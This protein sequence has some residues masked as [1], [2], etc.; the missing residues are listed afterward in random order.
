MRRKDVLVKLSEDY[1]CKLNRIH[2]LMCEV[3]E[4]KQKI[5]RIEF[6]YGMSRALKG[7]EKCH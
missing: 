7:V 1:V 3:I 2:N 4:M 6:F 5:E